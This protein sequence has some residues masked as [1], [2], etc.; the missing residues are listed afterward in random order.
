MAAATKTIPSGIW[1]LGFVSLLMQPEAIKAWAGQSAGM[2]ATGN[3]A[4]V[5]RAIW[6]GAIARL[7]G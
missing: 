5:A 1:A 4:D 3:A 6:A 7:G 2:A